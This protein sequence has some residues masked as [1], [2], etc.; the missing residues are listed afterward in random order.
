MYELNNK[1]AVVTG[2]SSGIG[3]AVALGLAAM[4]TNTFLL[5]RNTKSLEKIALAAQKTAAMSRFFQIDLSSVQDIRKFVECLKNE[6]E[7]IDILIH[8]AGI[9][10]IGPLESAS[11]EDFDNQ[12]EINVRAPFALTKYLLPLIKACQGQIVFINSSAGLNVGANLGQY[13][14][15]KFALKALSDSFRLEINSDGVRV[16][17]VFPGR[18]ASS[19]QALVHK[20]EGKE[21]RP[22]LLMQPENVA[23]VIISALT[24]PRS[25]EVTDVSVRSLI[26]SY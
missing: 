3:K 25:A 7:S 16:L 8:S 21:Y 4:G 19:M 1:F 22:A 6:V 15:T 11:L 9:I 5:G 14:A 24:L 26:K 23:D 13:S 12:Y 18:T 10:S 20:M 2:A 17:S